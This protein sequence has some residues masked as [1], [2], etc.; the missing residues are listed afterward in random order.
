MKKGMWRY[1]VSAG[2]LG[3]LGCGAAFCH[4]QLQSEKKKKKIKQKQSFILKISDSRNQM[5]LPLWV[6]REIKSGHI[7]A[8]W[9]H[10][11]LPA[12]LPGS[13]VSQRAGFL[14]GTAGPSCS[15]LSAGPHHGFVL[16]LVIFGFVRFWLETGLC[17]VV[18][19]VIP[20]V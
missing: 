18:L 6:S 15:A 14:H 7:G 2:E 9:L 12:V 4:L 11:H 10:H 3:F 20:V 13:P 5:L 1:A 19:A 8:A 16:Q 17:S